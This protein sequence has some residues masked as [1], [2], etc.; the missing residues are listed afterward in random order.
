MKKVANT[1]HRTQNTEH[2][3]QNTEHYL[4]FVNRVKC[5]AFGSFKE[6]II[7]P[8]KAGGRVNPPARVSTNEHHKFSATDFSP[9]NFSI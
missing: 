4:T 5:F 9:I 7:C 1:E 6:L 2:R 3:T 8:L